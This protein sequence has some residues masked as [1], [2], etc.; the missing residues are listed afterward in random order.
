MGKVLQ[1]LVEKQ[2]VDTLVNQYHP[3]SYAEPCV[4]ESHLCT[5]KYMGVEKKTKTTFL[6]KM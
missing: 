2:L 3:H 6:L 5:V 1:Q 4:L